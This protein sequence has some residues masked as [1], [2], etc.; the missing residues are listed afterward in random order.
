[1]NEWVVVMRFSVPADGSDSGAAATTFYE[2]AATVARLMAGFEGCRGVDI[3]RTSD[4]PT[5]WM[6]TSRWNS[7]GDYRRALSAYD[8]KLHGVPFL[9]QAIDEPTAFEVLF[10]V[11]AKGERAASGDLASDAGTIDRS[12]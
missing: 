11:D 1:M 3:G 6:V 10:T 5:I 12:R 2:D 4:D 7:V 8:M 9:S